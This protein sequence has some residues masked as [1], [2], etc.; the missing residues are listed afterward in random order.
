MEKRIAPSHKINQQLPRFQQQKM[1]KKQNWELKAMFD[2]ILRK[3][4]E[5]RK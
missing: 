4:R 5:V 3:E 2:E 1:P